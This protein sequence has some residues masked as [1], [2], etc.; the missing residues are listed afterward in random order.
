M[1]FRHTAEDFI[2][3]V[4]SLERQATEIM[5]LAFN[6][7]SVCRNVRLGDQMAPWTQTAVQEPKEIVV[8]EAALVVLSFPPWVGEKDVKG[9]DAL[10][11]YQSLDKGTSVTLDDPHI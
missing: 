9:G 11:G 7:I 1:R 3:V 10:L 5:G 8:E 6:V 4:N 2:V